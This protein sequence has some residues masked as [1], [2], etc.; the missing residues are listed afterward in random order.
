MLV[1][2]FHLDE[3]GVKREF[4]DSPVAKRRKLT[5]NCS[6]ERQSVSMPLAGKVGWEGEPEIEKARRPASVIA[7]HL[8]GKKVAAFRSLVLR[9]TPDFPRENR[10][11]L[12]L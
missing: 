10:V 9:I 4:R 6:L 2:R 8:R 1:S 11:F 7:Q 12:F 5:R 3:S